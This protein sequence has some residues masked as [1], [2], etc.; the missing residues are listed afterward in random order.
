MGPPQQDS[1]RAVTGLPISTYFSGV[2][3]RWLLDNVPQVKSAADEGRALFGTVDTWLIYMLTGG[4]QGGAH[5][6]DVTNASRTL[7]M[8][9][10]T[11]AW[12]EPTVQS[13]RIPPSLL[14]RIVSSAEVYGTVRA[15]A[16]AGVPIAGCLGDQ[17][18]A[19]LGQ[20]C[21]P[22]EAKN[23]YGTG[24]FMLLNTG[25]QLVPSSH[26]LLSTM[27]F[28]LGKDAPPQYALEG[29]VAIAGAAVSWL[30]DNLGI[31]KSAKEI[32]GL[33]ASV[34][35][36][37]GVCFVPAFNGLF[38]P[39]WRTDAR[40]CIVGMT[41]YCTK[42]HIARA[43]L[44]AICFQ[45]REVLEAMKADAEGLS[46]GA[47]RV[48]GGATQNALLMNMQADILGIPVVRP[49]DIET[50]AR[51]AAL[52]AGIG[53]GLWPAE[54]IF[55]EDAKGSGGGHTTFA[56]SIGEEEREARYALWSKAIAR[57]LDWA[58]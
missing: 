7:L 23:T 15:G 9:L 29:S 22:G 54:S 16:L 33:A 11:R 34:P 28:Q 45:S 48:D 39:H 17:H 50:T 32:E 13:L 52:A 40:G 36:S 14:P 43:T 55:Q 31:I 3:L 53:A 30:K 1:F 47:L 38:A 41:Q 42:A 35:D 58:H 51:G 46:V 56:P 25:S 2:K 18:A 44:E 20:R 49:E 37:A 26:G 5:V 10:K 8:D 57:S 19:T 4:A 27:A 21:R 24:C 6:I 12:H